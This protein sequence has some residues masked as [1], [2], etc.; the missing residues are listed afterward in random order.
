[1]NTVK[2]ICLCALMFFLAGCDAAPSVQAGDVAATSG[3]VT[4]PATAGVS[5]S[6]AFATFAGGCFWCMEP[7]Y[8]ELPGV[9]STTSGY[10]GGH[11]DN[12]DYKQVTAGGTGHYEAVQIVYDPTLVTYET[13]IDIYWI[14][15]DPLDAGGQFCDRGSSYRTAIFYHDEAQRHIALSSKAAVADRLA[16][17]IATSVVEATQFYPAEDYHQDYYQKN[18][19][20]Y[21]Y[22][23]RGCGRDARLKRIWGSVDH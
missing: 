20:R 3:A 17:V 7:P 9:I 18:P 11:A 19:L 4:R 13:L 14:N 22:Y 1:M 15:V 5:D 8:D 23:R 10:T 6:H 12:P 16:A 21:S 2:L